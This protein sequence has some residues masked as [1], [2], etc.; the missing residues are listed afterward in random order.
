MIHISIVFIEDHYNFCTLSISLHMTLSLS[1]M[2]VTVVSIW[3]S[4]CRYMCGWQVVGVFFKGGG[5]L[6]PCERGCL[7]NPIFSNLWLHAACWPRFM[8]HHEF[9]PASVSHPFYS[10]NSSLGLA[11]KKYQKITYLPICLFLYLFFNALLF[12]IAFLLFIPIAFFSLSSFWL[13]CYSS[14]WFYFSTMN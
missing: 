11:G 5:H 2:V 6:Q 3:W 13:V 4:L 12:K 7:N 14:M 1:L 10:I 9:W 8:C